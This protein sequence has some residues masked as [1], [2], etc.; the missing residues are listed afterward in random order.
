MPKSRERAVVVGTKSYGLYFGYTSAT[1]AE[2]VKTEALRLRAGR[3]VRY[4]YGKTGGITSLAAHGP[5]GSKA[6]QSRIGAPSDMLVT[7]VANVYDCPAVAVANF[8]A[9]KAGET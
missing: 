3:H 4:W 1:D 2:V 7:G 9:V 8:A 6:Q 5:C